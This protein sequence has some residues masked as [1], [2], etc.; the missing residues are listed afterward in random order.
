MN[1]IIY[2]PDSTRA[3][4]VSLYG[5]KNLKT[6]NYERMAKDGVVFEN[7]FSQNPVCTPSRVSM[8]TGQYVH[9]NGHRT[10][11][12]SIRPHQKSLL[13][14]LKNDGYEI[15]W[16]GKND[17]YSEEMVEKLIDVKDTILPPEGS[18]TQRFSKSDKRYYS[19]LKN[20]SYEGLPKKSEMEV[21]A[22]INFITKMHKDNKKYCV[23]IPVG[24]PHVP[25][26]A[27][28]KYHHMY[29]DIDLDIIKPIPVGIKP[30][31]HEL[32][33]EYRSLD[34][35][36][37]N[38][39]NDMQNI[40]SGMVSFSDMLLG[41]LLDT[42]NKLDLNSNTTLFVTSD[43]GEFA[44]DYGLVEK[45]P[46]AFTDNLV[47][48]P[49]VVKSP[50]CKKGLR[51]KGPIECF[52]LSATILDLANIELKHTSFAQT[53]TPHLKGE[54][55]DRARF[56]FSEGGYDRHEPHAFEGYPERGGQISNPE[57]IYY[58][59][60]KQ[61]QDYPESVCRTTMIRNLDFKLIKRTD[62]VNELYNLKDDPMEIDNLYY[63]DE[64]KDIKLDFESR[65]LNWYLKTSDTVPFDE[66][67]RN[68]TKYN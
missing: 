1:F 65:M 50:I 22:A 64:Y 2:Y 59:K 31:F 68:F 37:K 66:D 17:L 6:P 27:P 19:F 46:N 33:R 35:L 49:F 53:L 12:H 30:K 13:E 4:S 34:D 18:P 45:W 41:K 11:F 36:D 61:Q 14:Y 10:L 52:D 16:F 56:V 58:P 67:N 62:D 7:A 25:F 60:A 20:P 51:V 24:I 8:M 47:K 43:H 57:N 48:V 39:F 23:F 42:M 63:E 55:D 32:I 26:Y 29:D 38:H 9:N 28:K 40:Y 21:D 15:G 44:G 5:N 3:E 54:K